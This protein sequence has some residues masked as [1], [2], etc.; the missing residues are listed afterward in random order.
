VNGLPVEN[1]EGM[2]QGIK[3]PSCGRM[4]PLYVESC[5]CGLPTEM[6]RVQGGHSDL[7]SEI[8]SRVEKKINEFLDSRRAQ[9]EIMERFMAALVEKSKQSPA[10]KV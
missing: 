8:E 10:G 3:C 9:D 2:S 7:V 6:K 4:N 5:A 1:T